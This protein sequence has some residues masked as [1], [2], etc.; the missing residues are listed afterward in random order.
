MMALVERIASGHFTRESVRRETRKPKPAAPGR[1][2]AYVFNFRPTSKAFTMKLQ[3]R[4]GSV[5]REEIIDTLETILAELR[6]A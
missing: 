2:H 4:K 6:Q 1:P 5:E 3:F